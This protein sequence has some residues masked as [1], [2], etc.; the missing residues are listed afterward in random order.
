MK[1]ILILLLITGVYAKSSKWQN[2]EA[3]NSHPANAYHL[4]ENI[5]VLEIRAYGICNHYKTYHT[6]IGIYVT[7]KKQ[8]GK[9][10][11]KKFSKVTLD[12]SR[13]GDI[14]IP[15]DFKGNISRGFVLYKDGK[16]FRLNEISDIITCLGEIDTAAEAQLV[17]WLHSKYSG[18][19]QTEKSK[20]AYRPMVQDQ[21]YRKTPEGYKIV[22][23]YT[24]SHSYSRS[25]WVWCNDE[26]DFT[27]SAIVDK[28]GKIIGFKQVSKSKMK[29]ECSEV[30]CHSLPE[31]SS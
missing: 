26:Q 13:K 5:D 3:F 16:I 18:V 27:D 21:K 28:R 14:R 7:S 10:L 1:T 24:I 31:P 23:K 29:S 22:T 8:L 15:A 20:L 9:T 4:K 17:L 30:V 2:I 6:S 19:K 11:V 12:S 25:E